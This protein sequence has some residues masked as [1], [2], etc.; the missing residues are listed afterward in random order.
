MWDLIQDYSEKLYDKSDNITE[1]IDFD[2]DMNIYEGSK[3]T[4]AQF[5]S[6]LAEMR[7]KYKSSAGKSVAYHMVNI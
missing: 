4:L 3:W 1:L 7:L 6:N 2:M 5:M